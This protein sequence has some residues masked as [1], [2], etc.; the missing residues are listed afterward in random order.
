MVNKAIEIFKETFY[1][2]KKYP[3]GKCPYVSS[4]RIFL[5]KDGDL[6]YYAAM[7]SLIFIYLIYLRLFTWKTTNMSN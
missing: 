2:C 1:S 5:W 4:W 3:D 6:F 7:C